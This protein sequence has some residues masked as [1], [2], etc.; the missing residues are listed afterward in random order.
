MM[1]GPVA[2]IAT[3]L[4]AFVTDNV[5]VPLRSTSCVDV[6]VMVVL[7]AAFVVMAPVAALID[8]TLTLLEENVQPLPEVPSLMVTIQLACAGEPTVTDAGETDAVTLLTVTL[9][10]PPVFPPPPQPAM[11]AISE[12]VKAAMSTLRMA[13][14]LLKDLNICVLMGPSFFLN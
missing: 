2:V 3:G 9:P 5:A 7:P 1:A 12:R 11:R 6:A 13:N 14:T 4:T 8:A 10:P